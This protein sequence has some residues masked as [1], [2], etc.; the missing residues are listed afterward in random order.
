MAKA[1]LQLYAL[2][3]SRPGYSVHDVAGRAWRERTITYAAAPLLSPARAA[4]GPFRPRTWTSVDVT[5]LVRGNG[6][7]NVALTTAASSGIVF[8]SREAAS[9]RPRL[10]V[11][12]EGGSAVVVAA[13]DI[14]CDP[15]TSA[16]NRGLGTRSAC[17]QKYTADLV[18]RIAPVAVLNLG[19][20]QY[21][22][23]TLPRFAASYDRSWGAFKA[24]TWAVPG[25]IH[26]FYGGGEWYAYFGRRAGPAPYSPYS[27]D[28]AGWHVIVL[29]SQ[30]TNARVGGCDRSS[31]QYAWLQADLAAH[32]ARCTLALWHNAR[33]SSGRRHGRDKRTDAFVR[34]LHAAGADLVLS[35]HDHLY[36]RFAPQDPDGNR[37]DTRG[38]VQFVVGTGGKSLDSFGA[39]A[40]NSVARSSSAFGVLKLTLRSTGYDYEFVPEAGA[41]FTDSG[42][43]RC[44]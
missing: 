30:C 2:T 42:T 5:P 9:R 23:G 21:E 39:I 1:S 38:L 7:V 37:D 16:F 32:P 40:P 20:A 14:A 24:K 36:E 19:D 34:T 6:F 26:D 25:G 3:G 12:P 44:H 35:G 29:N 8:A 18:E 11:E 4:S 41:T 43:A 13:G 33:W 27:F 10:V 17:R 28:L 22:L 15:G 31:R